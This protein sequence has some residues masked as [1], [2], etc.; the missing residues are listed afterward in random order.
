MSGT[1]QTTSTS[2]TS[3]WRSP[4]SVDTDIENIEERVRLI[5]TLVRKVANS[6]S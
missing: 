3:D 5:S 6:D 2:N 1:N 4:S